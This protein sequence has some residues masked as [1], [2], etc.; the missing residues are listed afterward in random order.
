MTFIEA[1]QLGCELCG[2][3]VPMPADPSR[4]DR[5]PLTSKSKIDTF[6]T[7]MK[8]RYGANKA[9]KA[10]KFVVEYSNSPMETILELL[11]CLPKRYGGYGLPVPLM[12]HSIRLTRSE[13]REL[14]RS[15]FL[16]D[17]C[18]PDFGY[19]LE[20]YGREWHTDV[21]S[22]AHDA[23]RQS[24]LHYHGID[25]DIVTYEQLQTVSQV[26]VLATK[27]AKRLSIRLRKPSDLC[28]AAR[29]RLHRELIVGQSQGS[30]QNEF[31]ESAGC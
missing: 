12:N 11:L 28:I 24:D 10:L 21:Q 25:I 6:I 23:L 20:Y 14:G 5:E 16:C 30:L 3:Y 26:Q 9:A 29:E 8:G 18:W 19:A 31:P 22:V 7:S 27:V 15:A 13:A 1:I 2:T 17:L 4:R